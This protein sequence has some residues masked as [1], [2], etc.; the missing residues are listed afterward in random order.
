MQA[1]GT[2]Y[3]AIAK[4]LGVPFVTRVG[5]VVKRAE[6]VAIRIRAIDVASAYA[7]VSAA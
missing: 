2:L 6:E 3:L 7:I 5:P 1:G 4:R